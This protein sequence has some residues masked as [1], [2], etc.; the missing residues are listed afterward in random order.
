[1]TANQLGAAPW[2]KADSDTS[3]CDPIQDD[4]EKAVTILNAARVF[5]RG[6]I[7]QVK[8]GKGVIINASSDL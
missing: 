1:M 7:R 3:A 4:R 2:A 8:A 5:R 6:V